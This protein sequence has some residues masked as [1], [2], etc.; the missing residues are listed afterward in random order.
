M[1]SFMAAAEYVQLLNKDDNEGKP[2]Q[3]VWMTEHQDVIKFLVPEFMDAEYFRR[4]YDIDA[5]IFAEFC[6][7]FDIPT[8]ESA[9]R[10]DMVDGFLKIQGLVSDLAMIRDQ[11]ERLDDQIGELSEEQNR[12][13]NI[14]KG[15]E[16]TLAYYTKEGARAPGSVNS[17]I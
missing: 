9:V 17:D 10:A 4:H 1:S 3:S 12:L 7:E 14:H 8:T 6:S 15:I 5:D 2:R 16:T 11:V 13:E